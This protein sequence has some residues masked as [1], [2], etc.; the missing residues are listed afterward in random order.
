MLEKRQVRLHVYRCAGRA[1]RLA[2]V[3]QPAEAGKAAEA[4]AKIKAEPSH[5][6]SQLGTAIRQ[7]LNDFRGSTLSGIV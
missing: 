2:E 4:I 7:V 5:D 3:T 1:Q 6:S